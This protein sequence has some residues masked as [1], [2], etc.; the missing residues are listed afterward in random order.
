[1]TSRNRDISDADLTFVASP[2][3]YAVLFGHI[4]YMYDLDVLRSYAFEDDEL[5]LRFLEGDKL[6]VLAVVTVDPFGEL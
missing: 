1:M 5:P 4:N 2:Y 6:D 3:I